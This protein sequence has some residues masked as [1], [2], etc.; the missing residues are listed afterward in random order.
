MKG[1]RRGVLQH[2]DGWLHDEQGERL[3]CLA[4]SMGT[5]KSAVAQT[6]AEIC[7]AD[8]VLGASFFCSRKFQGGGD[9]QFIFPTL[10]FQLAH[11]YPRFREEL[12]KVLREC[13]NVGRE[14]LDLQVEK[15]IVGPFEATQIQTLIIIDGLD[16]CDG[17]GQ[18]YITFMRSLI[19]HMGGIPNV[20]FL[21]TARSAQVIN[22]VR[23]VRTPFPHDPPA[24]PTARNFTLGGFELDDDIKLFLRTLLR[25]HAEAGGR[26]NLPK[27]WPGSKDI[28]S[29]CCRAGGCFAY[30]SKFVELYTSHHDL[31]QVQTLVLHVG[32]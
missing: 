6:F 32:Q 24:H 26:R 15:L 3:L 10:A 23:L 28:D 21:I 4:G 14:L 7:F 19:N 17:Q 8:G 22:L 12:V 30:A 13:P 5:G 16:E 18:N 25:D 20:K 9:I 31:A 2:L 27:G 11:R 29:L 1:T